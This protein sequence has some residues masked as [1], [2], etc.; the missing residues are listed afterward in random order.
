MQEEYPKLKRGNI[1]HCTNTVLKDITQTKYLEDS[2]RREVGPEFG[3]DLAEIH[4]HYNHR[5]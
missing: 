5:R 3:F 1:V 2:I 4:K